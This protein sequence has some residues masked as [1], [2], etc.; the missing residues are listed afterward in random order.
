MKSTGTETTRAERKAKTKA[1]NK[2]GEIPQ[3][4]EAG[5]PKGPGTEAAK[6]P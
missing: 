5:S 3:A 1:A 6:K 2:A 4:G